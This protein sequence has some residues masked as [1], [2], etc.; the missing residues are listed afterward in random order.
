MKYRILRTM[1]YIIFY[2]I[3][4]FCF[5]RLLYLKTADNLLGPIL[6]IGALISTYLLLHFESYTEK[7]KTEK[8]IFITFYTST[9]FLFILL[10]TIIISNDDSSVSAEPLNV[11]NLLLMALG[12]TLLVCTILRLVIHARDITRS[13]WHTML[14]KFTSYN[15]KDPLV[16]LDSIKDRLSHK[17]YGDI[18]DISKRAIEAAKVAKENNKT[19]HYEIIFPHYEGLAQKAR[20]EIAIPMKAATRYFSFIPAILLFSLWVSTTALVYSGAQMGIWRIRFTDSNYYTMANAKPGIAYRDNH[21]FINKGDIPDSIKVYFDSSMALWNIGANDTSSIS[22]GSLSDSLYKAGLNIGRTAYFIAQVAT[23]LGYGDWN[24]DTHLDETGELVVIGIC[25]LHLFFIA[26]ILTATVS[27]LISI[28][29]A[30]NHGISDLIKHYLLLN[31]W[32]K[33][34]TQ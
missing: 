32:H 18:D 10:T 21:T 12:L 28:G 4:P 25:T 20:E 7:S 31:I 24:K 19:L 27:Y 34:Q 2:L 16:Q 22:N 11:Y 17:I 29:S 8:I 33:S 3:V 13:E 15:R 14:D 30:V 5:L 9:I 6:L 26:F 23:T 1:G